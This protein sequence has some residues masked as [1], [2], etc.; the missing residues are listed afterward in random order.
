MGYIRETAA[1]GCSGCLAI[2]I[3][4]GICIIAGIRV[5]IG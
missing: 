2:I 5:L 1:N 3:V 4:I